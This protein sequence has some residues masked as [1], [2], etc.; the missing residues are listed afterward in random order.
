MDPVGAVRRFPIR[1]SRWAVILMGL[2]GIRC[3]NSFVEV[4][5]SRMQVRMGWAFRLEAPLTSVRSA[6]PDM[7][8]VLGWGVHGWNGRW[9]V[10]GSSSGIVRIDIDPAAPGRVIGFPVKVRR[11]RVAVTEPDVL[12]E[13]LSSRSEPE[14]QSS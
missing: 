12:I 3:T 14:A 5:E 6:N 7:S 1:F 8:L 11:L 13:T 4:G 2:F 10:N 9:L